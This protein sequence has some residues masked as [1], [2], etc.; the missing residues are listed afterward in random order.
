MLLFAPMVSSRLP[1]SAP[2]WVNRHFVVYVEYGELRLLARTAHLEGEEA[3]GR[4]R[5]MLSVG[6]HQGGGRLTRLR[7]AFFC[8]IGRGGSRW[9]YYPTF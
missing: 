9:G 5:H 4:A 7:R 1:L 3:R 2:A 8:W 6:Q